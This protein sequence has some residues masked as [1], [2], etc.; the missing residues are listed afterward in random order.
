MRHGALEAMRHA[1]C[2]MRHAAF[3]MRHGLKSHQ[4]Q[5]QSCHLR[6]GVHGGV[7]VYACVQLHGSVGAARARASATVCVHACMHVRVHP[8]MEDV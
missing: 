4:S 7:R 8:C 3:G 2:G 1:A 6:P 5:H